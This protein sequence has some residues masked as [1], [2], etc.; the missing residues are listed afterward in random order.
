LETEKTARK[1]GFLMFSGGTIPGTI[2][3]KFPGKI[4]GTV[5]DI[6]V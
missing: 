3:G 6:M 1:R 2:P 5:P 4:P